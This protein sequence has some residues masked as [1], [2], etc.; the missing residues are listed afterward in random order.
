MKR[1]PYGS[2][3]LYVRT[4]RNGRD[5]WYGHWRTNGRQVKRKIG[6]KRKD[7]TRH[8][9]TR[10]QAEAELRRLI[11]EVEV[12]APADE[13]LS[14]AEVGCLYVADLE[15]RGRKPETVR[16]AE[17]A[18]RV[19]FAPFFG[20]CAVDTI[21]QADVE[22]LAA[23]MGMSGARSRRRGLA[24]KSV[25]NYLGTLSALFRFAMRRGYV[26]ENPVSL[27]ELPVVEISPD[28]RFLT[29]TEVRALVAA[30]TLGPYELI[31]RALF[32]TA[33]MTGLRLGE[34]RALRWRRRL[35]RRTRARAA[36]LRARPVRHAEDPSRRA[37]CPACRR[38]SRRARSTPQAHRSAWGQRPRLR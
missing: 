21:R 5:T 22:R 28:I 26:R 36:K 8:G 20:E 19:H 2:G 4:D 17:V 3:S 30:V 1:R 37:Q 24:P 6:L 14:I 9:L 33:A 29:P 7:G 25:R 11:R 12:A 35:A 16:A 27:V 23:Q 13:R 32:L 38:G 34:L 18:V 31:D 15:R 10:A